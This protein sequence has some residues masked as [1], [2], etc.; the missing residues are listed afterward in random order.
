M[1]TP[2]LI[3]LVGRQGTG[4]SYLARLVAARTAAELL[5]TDALRQELFDHPRYTRAEHGVVYAEAHRRIATSLRAGR[6]V[7]FDATNLGEQKRR[8]VYQLADAARARL[9]VALTYAPPDVIRR[10][11]A[12]RAAGLDP[13]DHSTADWRVYRRAGRCDPISRP[14]LLVNTAVDLAQAVELI[15]D[16]AGQI[17]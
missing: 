3:M 13:L 17:Q 5:Q 1:S 14:H 10:R 11:L 4:K 6:S 12:A 15:A 2:A 9:I 16:R 7:I 8:A